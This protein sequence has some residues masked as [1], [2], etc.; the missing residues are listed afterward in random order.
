MRARDFIVEAV[1]V[2]FITNYI[3]KHHDENLH[4]DYLDNLNKFSKF[5]LKN[6]PVNSLKLELS[7]LDRAK[8]EQYKKMNFDTAPPIVVGDGYVLD[9]YHRATAAKELGIPTI[10]AYVGTKAIAEGTYDSETFNIKR[11]PLN[12]PLLIQKGAIF[13]THPHSEQ[14]WETGANIP[15]WQFSLITLHNLYHLPWCAD[16]KKYLKPE[17]YNQVSKQIHSVTDGKYNQILWSIK[18]LGIPE[19][20]AFLDAVKENKMSTINVD[21]A[22]QN[23]PPVWQQWIKTLPQQLA[24]EFIDERPNPNDED[25]QEYA[26]LKLA[27]PQP[28]EVRVA[29]LLKVQ[30]NQY[31]ISQ[32]PDDVIADIN[33]K[34][35]IKISSGK[36]YDLNP[37][38]NRQYAQMSGA[39]AAPSV[40]INGVITFG[41]GRFTSACLRGDRT[42]RVWD[43]R[44]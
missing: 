1:D 24:Q 26:K 39:T 4:P 34:W 5:I 20:Q 38:R 13:V 32:A 12:V 43:L 42:M 7:G 16:A 21:T 25:I 36:K 44:G 22:I 31:N 18:K 10:K 3:K 11:R 35:G 9:G 37:A 17:A 23:T 15:D 29:E 2:G 30:G 28:R 8:V 6:I 14:G 27:S 41:V 40:M 19:E 33:Q